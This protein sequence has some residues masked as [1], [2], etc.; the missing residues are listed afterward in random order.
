MRVQL[1]DLLSDSARVSIHSY[2]TLF[3][4]INTL[5]SSLLSSFMEILFCKA[6]GPH[7]SLIP[8]LVARISCFRCC[9]L[10]SV[11]GWE[12]RLCSK[13]LQAEATADQTRPLE[14]NKLPGHSLHEGAAFGNNL[15]PHWKNHPSP[16]FPTFSGD[17]L[18][19]DSSL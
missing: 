13:P 8:C 11:S 5:L 16:N 1:R 19:Q 4:L 18:P 15:F 2:C 14:I 9:D 12:P 17:Q 6:E 10:A 3:L 7:L